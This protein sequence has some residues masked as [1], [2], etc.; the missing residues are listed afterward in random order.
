[1]DIGPLAKWRIHGDNILAEEIIAKD[2]GPPNLCVLESEKDQ[3]SVVQH[4]FESA[5]F[6]ILHLISHLQIIYG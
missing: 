2:Y 1:M 3:V 6:H 5:G 4:N